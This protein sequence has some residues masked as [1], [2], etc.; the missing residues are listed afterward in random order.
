MELKHILI[1]ATCICA[2]AT[3]QGCKKSPETPSANAPIV[4]TKPVTNISSTSVVTGGELVNANNITDKGILWGTD[5]NLLKLP[6]S[7][8]IS[9]GAGP[10]NFTDTL[11]NLLSATTYY[12]RAYAMYGSE[13]AY[14]AAVK[15]ITLLPEPTVY[16]AGYNGSNAAYW[17]NGKLFPL[18]NGTY[19][20]SI[21]VV[22]GD[23]YAAGE[24]FFNS[25]MRALCWK[26][27]IVV[28][29]P[30]ALIL[31]W[32]IPFMLLETTYMPPDTS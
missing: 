30:T 5:S 7:N 10:S 27:G 26:N 22:G 23:V 25:N 16:L 17:K 24:G 20:H 3:E 14:G 11:Q 2:L 15:F 29:S 18:P 31:L 4:T 32:L 6:Y 8:K 21:Q 19:A 12:V 9:N 1:I 13:I 28:L